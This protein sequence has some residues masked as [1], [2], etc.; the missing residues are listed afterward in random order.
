MVFLER[1]DG[2]ASSIK[3]AL[4]A[5]A[6]DDNTFGLW[7]EGMYG[8]CLGRGAGGVLSRRAS[9]VTGRGLQQ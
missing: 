7:S 3:C 9:V 4:R 6:I 5:R 2:G 1:V 8:Q